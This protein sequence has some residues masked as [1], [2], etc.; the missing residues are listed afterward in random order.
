MIWNPLMWWRQK[1][2][3]WRAELTYY[4]KGFGWL[5]DK[6]IEALYEIAQLDNALRGREQDGMKE[7]SQ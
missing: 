2:A 3:Q 7:K 1:Q 4:V 5:T 6:Q